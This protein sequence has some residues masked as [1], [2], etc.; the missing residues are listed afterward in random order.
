MRRF[1]A[2]RFR[3]RDYIGFAAYASPRDVDKTSTS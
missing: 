2:V 1:D 3:D